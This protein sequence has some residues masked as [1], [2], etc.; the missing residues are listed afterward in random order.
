[1]DEKEWGTFHK[2]FKTVIIPFMRSK[3]IDV[4]EYG[5]DHEELSKMME[6]VFCEN[7]IGCEKQKIFSYDYN[8]IVERVEV[9][10]EY[11]FEKIDDRFFQTDYQN[12]SYIT[13]EIELAYGT[14]E[15]YLENGYGYAAII[16]NEIVSR[17]IMTCSY[18]DESNISVNTLQTHRNK[19]LS[20]YLVQKTVEETL[21][22]NKN[23][24]WDC[25]QD[26]IASEKT[27]LRCGFKMIR[28]D[29]IYWF[30]I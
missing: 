25:S 3:G 30:S 29:N 15:N 1:M 6:G 10:G 18:G 19:R 22:R 5:V 12:M 11:M 21:S 26:N 4:F 27:A 24:I 13:E 20:S 17:A 23:P 14:Q 8:S 9:L 28:E 16:E 2:W 7:E